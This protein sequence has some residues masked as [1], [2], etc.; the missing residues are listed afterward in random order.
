[1]VRK[2]WAGVRN[3]SAIRADRDARPG[4]PRFLVGVIG[5]VLARRRERPFR[6]DLGGLG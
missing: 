4:W 5:L 2:L 6:G 3:Q 1:M